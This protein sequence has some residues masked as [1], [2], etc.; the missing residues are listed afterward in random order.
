[1]TAPMA[2][3]HAHPRLVATD[4]DGTLLRPDGTV[5]P[6]TAAALRARGRRR[7]R[8]RVRDRPATALAARSSRAHVAGHGVAICANGAAVLEVGTGRVLAERGMS[9]E[10]VGRHRRPR[11]R[12]PG[13]VRT[14]CT[15]PSRA[16]HGFA[17]ETAVPLRPPGAA[18]Q[19]DRPTASRTSSAPSTFKL[20][21][22]TA[23]AAG[24]RLRRRARRRSSATSR[25]S[26]TRE[27]P[28]WGRSPARASPRP[29]RSP[30]GRRP[31]AST[32]RT[33]GRSATPRTTCRCSA[34]RAT[35]FAVANAHP[36]GPRGRDPPLRL[37]R[38]RR[39]RRRAGPRG[40]PGRAA[41]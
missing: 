39:R 3:A 22:R 12:R 38:R 21:V 19:P 30:A 14:T 40:C 23:A 15:S 31:A 27:R 5:S 18:R 6:R 10:L 36:D 34:G 17:H 7:H 4:L 16:S 29:R 37:E 11:P 24:R 20:L 1:M 25:S 26:P 32:R 28:G 9:R 2:P 33:S 8:G 35:S 13:A 41:S